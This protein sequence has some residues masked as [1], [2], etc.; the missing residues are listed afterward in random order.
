MKNVEPARKP[1]DRSATSAQEQSKTF[2][3]WRDE[4]PSFE[5]DG[6]RLYLPTGDTP[7]DGAQLAELWQQAA[8]HRG[9][10]LDPPITE[11][12]SD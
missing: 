2:D 10:R 5:V 9:H 6:E 7:M 8:A 12:A 1:P 4:L 3:S 11:L